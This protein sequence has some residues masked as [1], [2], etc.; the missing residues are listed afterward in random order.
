MNL[1]Q[2][3]LSVGEISGII[4]AVGV[5]ISLIYVALQ[6]R[7]NTKAIKGATYQSIIS[8]YAEIEARI[9]QDPE[10]AR[11]YRQGCKK[12]ESLTED[13]ALRFTELVCSI[14]NLYENVHYQH[15]NKLLDESLWLGWSEDMKI[16]LKENPGLA[17]FWKKKRKLY[18]EDFR[19]YVNRQMALE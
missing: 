16:R 6:V 10:T 1:A 11:I 13:E 15:K 8:A 5:V 9:S 7:D 2:V 14:F 4:Q 3:S 17:N 18:N 12:F 19:K